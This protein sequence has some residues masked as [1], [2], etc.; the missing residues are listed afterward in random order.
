MPSAYSAESNPALVARCIACQKTL[1]TALMV[2]LT[3]HE[4]GSDT[5]IAICLACAGNGWRPPG[6]AGVYQWHS[7]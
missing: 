5:H 3:G 6:F 7:Q 4:N 1:P 2:S